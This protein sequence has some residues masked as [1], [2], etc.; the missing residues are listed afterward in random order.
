MV[1]RYVPLLN[2]FKSNDVLLFTLW[3]KKVF[4]VKSLT[5]TSALSTP[6]I[7][8]NPLLGFGNQ[9]KENALFSLIPK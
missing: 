6:L 5:I 7:V 8:T 2:P 1:T 4:P 9:V 3:L